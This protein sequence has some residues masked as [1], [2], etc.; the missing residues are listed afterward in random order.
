MIVTVS[1]FYCTE[2]SRVCPLPVGC[3]AQ[4]LIRT[5]TRSATTVVGTDNDEEDGDHDDDDDVDDGEED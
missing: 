2:L 5:S 4:Q 3:T 1:V